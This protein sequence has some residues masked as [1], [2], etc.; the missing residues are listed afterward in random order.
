[1]AESTLA[2]SPD[3]YFV[4]ALG[5]RLDA[6]E[7]ARTKMDEQ[8]AEAAASIRRITRSL[9]HTGDRFGLPEVSRLARLVQTA[10]HKTLPTHLER[11]ISVLEEVVG[12]EAD[13]RVPILVVEPDVETADL[14]HVMLSG[15]NRRVIVTETVE[16]A[17]QAVNEHDFE[18]IVL[19]LDL[20]DA[21]GR[22][23]LMQLRERR[24]TGVTP[25][26][27]LADSRDPAVRTE[28]FALGADHVFSK[29][30]D[31]P[32]LATAVASRLQR[33]VSVHSKDALTGLPD[34]TA[35]A[36]MFSELH[37]SRDRRS[38]PTCLSALSVDHFASLRAIYGHLR[39][40]NAV[41]R[42][43]DLLEQSLRHADLLGRWSE[44]T[45]VIV[46]PDTSL[47]EAAAV[48]DRSLQIIR[49]EDF[50]GRE[51]QRLDLSCSAGI[52][53]VRPG[54]QSIHAPL[55]NARYFLNHARKQGGGR[56]SME[57]KT[58]RA[59]RDSILI[60]ED[61]ALTA[62]ILSD[63]LR[64]EGFEVFH[65]DDG[66]E[67]YEAAA[68]LAP[69]LVLLD[70]KLPSMDGFEL[71]TRLRKMPSYARKPI[72]MLT[73]MSNDDDLSRGFKLG[74]DDYVLKPFSPTELMA[75]IHRC[76]RRRRFS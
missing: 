36:D 72:L 34:R 55:R 65:F 45:F 62:T 8:P 27:V 63:R 74:A 52:T 26:F 24:K 37:S 19:A 6:L 51:H 29:P 44:G 20:P 71:L 2:R 75:R 73:A 57:G 32:S 69:G 76:Y 47:S 22:N 31:P 41:R 18:L 53:E 9:H 28:C 10:S 38:G 16:E 67:A 21:D 39:A 11:L 3:G 14:L 56:I 5:S 58:P 4:E 46:L 59:V 15:S 61:D 43:A 68:N 49:Q 33:Q 60:V 25:V 48:L 40:E 23:L 64:R 70:V 7:A 30:F 35:L 12:K 17:L 42:T 66:Q 13:R 1:M 54:A 50:G